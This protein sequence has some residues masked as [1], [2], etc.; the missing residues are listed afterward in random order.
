MSTVMERPPSELSPE[1]APATPKRSPL[2]RRTILR[3]IGLT[4][5]TA[6]V[7]TMPY[8]MNW[9]GS[10]FKIGRASCRERV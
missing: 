8:D 9:A 1:R 3:T 6:F 7:L 4:V 2:N 10:A 5:L